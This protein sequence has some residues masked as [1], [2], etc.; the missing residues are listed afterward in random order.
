MVNLRNRYMCP[1]LPI[2]LYRHWDI[3]IAM[4]SCRHNTDNSSVLH[5]LQE[6]SSIEQDFL[7]VIEWFLIGYRKCRLTLV[8]REWEFNDDKRSIGRLLRRYWYNHWELKRKIIEQRDTRIERKYCKFT[9]EPRK[10]NPRVY[11]TASI[12]ICESRRNS[13]R[14]DSI[15]ANKP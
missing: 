5:A 3:L 9:I 14:T 8:K 11:A 12:D 2:W 7:D 4:R 13:W 6:Y 10:S 15:D 1:Q